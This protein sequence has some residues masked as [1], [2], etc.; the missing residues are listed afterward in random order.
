MH[1]VNRFSTVV[2]DQQRLTA[3]EMKAGWRAGVQPSARSAID[4][5]GGID[6]VHK[7]I[8]LD[9]AYEEYCLRREN[10]EHLIAADFVAQFSQ[11]SRTLRRQI[12]IS[13]Q[14]KMVTGISTP[15]L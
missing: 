10:G 9:L 12:E 13:S 11:I 4:N 1:A 5:L 7:S 15:S 3:A 6:A 14:H 8:Q 2:L